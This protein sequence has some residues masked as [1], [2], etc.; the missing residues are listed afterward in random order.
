[1]RGT[2]QIGLALVTAVA[3]VCFV[4]VNRIFANLVPNPDFAIAASNSSGALD[5]SAGVTGDNSSAYRDTSTPNA[6]DIAD[7]T[8][9]VPDPSEGAGAILYSDLFALPSSDATYTF[10]YFSR[11][12]GGQAEV[13]LYDAN[14]GGICSDDVGTTQGAGWV[15]HTYT[16]N[17]GGSPIPSYANV[18][19]VIGPL[20][21]VSIDNVYF[22]LVPE[23]TSLG[24][25]ACALLG[26]SLRR[27]RRTN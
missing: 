5:W 23:P 7:E 22:D 13:G 18:M 8:L 3:F 16:I 14:E 17:V 12:T 24:I 25:A 6:G 21:A 4:D 10:S 1:M 11:G 15:Q 20:S 26:L 27:R 19:F 9:S 2:T